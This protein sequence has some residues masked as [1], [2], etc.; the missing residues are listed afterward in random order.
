[1]LFRSVKVEKVVDSSAL[2][3]AASLAGNPAQKQSKTG[4]PS[5]DGG[6]ARKDAA[7][8]RM[9]QAQMR[10]TMEIS[11]KKTVVLNFPAKPV[12]A[13][14]KMKGNGTRIVARGVENKKKYVLEILEISKE[15]MVVLENTPAGD[16]KITFV[17]QM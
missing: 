16:L 17:R 4:S 6:A 8:D 10:A 11:A 13:T 2:Q 5:G 9:V 1:M 3:A 7:L 14:W 12:N 15:Q